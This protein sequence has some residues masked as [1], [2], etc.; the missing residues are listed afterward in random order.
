M[1]IA[2]MAMDNRIF[3]LD[4]QLPFDWGITLL[5]VFTL[6]I[7]MSYLLFN[8]ARELMRKRQQ[9]IQDQL[10]DAKKVNDQAEK[11]KNQYEAKLTKVQEE[12]DVLL[13]E[14]RKKALGKETEIV[15][16]AQDEAARIKARASKEVELEKNKVQ[17]E[18][19][20]EMIEVASLMASKFVEENMDEDKQAKLIDETLEKMGD[21]T[22]QN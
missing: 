13:I 22:W 15:N 8:P 4:V 6:F 12:V 1:N 11:S 7:L 9:Y 17:N 19:K 18:M 5:A 21:N 3:G 20:Q 10:D 14:A 16:E 2:L